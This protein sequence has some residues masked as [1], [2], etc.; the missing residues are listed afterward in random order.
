MASHNDASFINADLGNMAS[1]KFCECLGRKRI[2][3][4]TFVTLTSCH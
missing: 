4:V 1:S 3:L 2:S